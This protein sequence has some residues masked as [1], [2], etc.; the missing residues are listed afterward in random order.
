M[1]CAGLD[2]AAASSNPPATPTRFGLIQHHVGTPYKLLVA[3]SNGNTESN[4]DAGRHGQLKRVDTEWLL[5]DRQNLFRSRM[6]K[7][8]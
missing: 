8:F 6:A 1:R 5:G 7:R 4:A 3:L 2:W